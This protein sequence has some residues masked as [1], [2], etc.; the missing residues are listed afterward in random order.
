MLK[1]LK[2][3]FLT[4]YSFLVFIT[5]VLG[6]VSA[7]N[8]YSLS[9]SI[10]NLMT[11][12]YK[13]ISAVSFML[14]ALDGQN[15]ATLS[16]INMDK[17]QAISS[18]NNYSNDFYKWYYLEGGNITEN[19]EKELVNEVQTSYV[20]YLTLFSKL[21]ELSLQPNTDKTTAFYNNEIYP[22]YNTLK[23]L[24][25][26]ISSLNEK[27]MFNGRERVTEASENSMYFILILSALSVLGGFAVAWLSLRKFLS[28]LYAL[29]DN[30]KALKEGELNKHTEIVSEDEIGELS[31]EFNDMTQRLLEFEQSTLGKI[32]AEKNKSLAIVKSISDP[33]LVMD[34]DY[35]IA[36]VNDAFE[37]L[38]DLKEEAVI[39]RYFL[40]VIRNGELYDYIKNIYDLRD[41]EAQKNIFYFNYNNKDYYYNVLVTKLNEFNNKKYGLVVLFQNVTGLKQVEKLKSDFIATV[42]HE[43]KTPFTSIMMGSSLIFE[44]AAGSINEKQK[45]I[46][47]T[48]NEE[49]EK[50]LNLVNNLLQISKLESSKSIFKI[51]P[52][53]VEAI[54]T[55]SI[56]GFIEKAKEKNISLQYNIM[57]NGLKV[58]VDFDKT[59]WVLNNLISNAL[60]YTHSGD[61]ILITAFVKQNKMCISVKDMGDGI[62]EGYTEKIFEK[63]VQV[64]GTEDKGTGLGLA[65]AKEIVEA[66]SGEIWCE[67]KLG[68]GSTFTFTLPLFQEE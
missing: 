6:I 2:G 61:N 13:S 30:M 19:G 45:E 28:P 1:T 23:K 41:G 43:F 10:Q 39:N 48:I 54:I 38:F 66:Q 22:Q 47:S 12:N 31:K 57:D 3:K 50:L 35:K 14:E 46:M 34:T 49:S 25:R 27:A 20:K 68:E 63:F 26:D 37:E 42:S 7:I 11:D 55:N 53:S 64:E 56:K 16:Y 58:N 52:H 5:A 60:K 67:S 29:R 36:L 65:I 32:L 51:E 59:T 24:L 44:E 62:P 9:R 33:I 21:Q 8:V 17:N 40:E 18:F 15:A 4:V